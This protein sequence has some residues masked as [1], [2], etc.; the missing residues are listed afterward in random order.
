M[1]LLKYYRAVLKQG[2]EP[3]LVKTVGEYLWPP[4]SVAVLA[5]GDHDD[6]LTLNVDRH[7]RLPG[8]LINTGEDP[9][10]CKA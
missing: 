8:G 5:E 1:S 10:R 6:V 7:H 2:V 9:N 3:L 4:T